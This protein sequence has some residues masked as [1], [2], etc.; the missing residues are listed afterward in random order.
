MMNYDNSNFSN[1]KECFS[2]FK[3]CFLNFKKCDVCF[4]LSILLNLFI[5]A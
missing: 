5:L 4:I 1:F 2:N 3:E